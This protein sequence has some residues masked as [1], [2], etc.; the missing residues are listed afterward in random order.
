LQTPL[1]AA[2]TDLE[3]ALAHP[4]TTDLRETA[5]DVLAANGRMERL[6]RDRL[7]LAR[8]DG[9]APVPP[10][11][12]VDLD[13]IVMSEAVR[14]RGDG[15]VRVDTHGVAPAAVLGRRE[16]LARAVR[17]LLDNAQRYAGSRVSVQLRGDDRQVTVAVED[18]G[19]G[20]PPGDR[21][22]VFERFTRLDG[23]RGR[24]SGGS[25]LGLAITRE[26][27]QAHGGVISVVD[28]PRGARFVITLPAP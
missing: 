9:A 4:E 5:A 13:D 24:A 22:R 8:A 26:I 2:R 3:V 1:A 28:S 21:E 14:V 17:N 23:A 20:I 15:R 11:A 18:D 7:Y 25:G 10:A 12:L 16:D 19:P 27:V 6:V